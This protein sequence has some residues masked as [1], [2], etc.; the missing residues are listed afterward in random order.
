VVL[1]ELLAREQLFR[2]LETEAAMDEVTIAPTP[3][4]IRL[5]P[6][7]H[8]GL[9]G[10]IT[11]GV[12]KDPLQRPNAAMFG[13]ALDQWCR[14]QGDVATPERLQAHLARL[15]P[16]TYAPPVPVRDPKSSSVP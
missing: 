6:D 16:A 10:L 1:F 7:V 5:L 9:S 11:L 4:I 15:F 8:V 13:L 3:N 12:S 14:T 2:E